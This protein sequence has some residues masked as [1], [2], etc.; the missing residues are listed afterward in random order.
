MTDKSKISLSQLSKTDQEIWDR[1][2]Q[3]LFSVN[4]PSITPRADFPKMSNKLDLHGLT[5]QH[6]FTTTN[7]FLE[8][9]SKLSTKSVTIVCGKGGKIA[10]ELPT[11]CLANSRVTSCEPIM[12]SRGEFGAYKVVF[13]TRR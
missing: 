1:Y 3:K 2:T 6:A 11:W 7:L 5:I 13:K 12:D 4:G 9:H 10:E 8:N